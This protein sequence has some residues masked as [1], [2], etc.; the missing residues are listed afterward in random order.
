I[1][2]SEPDPISTIQPLAPPALDRV[3]RTCL[4]KDPEDRWQTAHDVMLELKWIAEG[5]TSPG[6]TDLRKIRDSRRE[7]W[8]WL[9]AGIFFL[10][11]LL[12]AFHLIRNKTQPSQT[13]R[14]FVNPPENASFTGS[15]A[16][17]PDGSRM[18]FTAADKNGVASL[19]VRPLNSLSAQALPGTEDAEYPFWS[20]DGRSIGFFAKEKLKRI[21][22]AGGPPVLVADASADPRGGTWNRSGDILFAPSF[23]SQIRRVPARGGKATQATDFRTGEHSHRWP[24][25]LPDGQHFL[26][27]MLG[28]K[29][30]AGSVYL[31]SLNGGK[32]KLLLNVNSMLA[33][34]PP[35][36]LFFVREQTLMMQRFDMKNLILQDEPFP[37]AEQ[38]AIHP[39]IAGFAA[40]SVSQNGILAFRTDISILTSLFWI[41]RSGRQL[42]TVGAP[43]HYLWPELSPDGKQ[44]VI[45]QQDIQSHNGDIWLIDL[46]RGLPSRLTFD[47]ADDVAAIWSPD[48]KWIAFTSDRGEGFNLYM[49]NADG[50][51][52]DQPLLQ[53]STYIIA[54]DWSP[55]GKHI[56]YDRLDPIQ[57]QDIW[58]LPL[59]GERK[60][61][62]FLATP[63]GEWGGQFSPDGRWIA[64]LSGESGRNQ[65]YMKPFP[66]PGQ[67]LQIS[68][69]GGQ[70]IRWRKD[71]KELFYIR[72][73]GKL[74]SVQ[75]R[76][77][78]SVEASAPQALF[79]S[80]VTTDD[81]LLPYYDVSADG[82]RFIIVRPLEARKPGSITVVLNWNAELKH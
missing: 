16:L 4:A 13:V 73:D 81:P 39:D 48:G 45:G 24:L 49:K 18:A 68:Y 61:F 35:D 23:Q 66:G 74:M 3:V 75:L 34:A 43:A 2:S 57:K 5:A 69:D 79:D 14:L 51:G 71:G 22:I 11:T 28:G 41:D 67:S 65:I 25:F 60:P 76:V 64:Y 55:D 78:V 52:G 19:W 17:S 31:G 82:Q 62:P 7:R 36:Y 70:G 1:L 47:P 54:C 63:A 50:R 37:L 10:A 12:S 32:P 6:L 53:P 38:L 58:V 15:I 40:F 30:E 59:F 80:G 21:E 29:G 27:L 20:P 72:G 42:Q 26:Y 56:L 9:I 8:A 44:L 46:A 77:G 33:F